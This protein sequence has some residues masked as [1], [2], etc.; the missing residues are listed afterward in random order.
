MNCGI[1]A[2]TFDDNNP[3]VY[4]LF[5]SSITTHLHIFQKGV[6]SE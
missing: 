2:P 3:V 5:G 1:P 6:H 4:D